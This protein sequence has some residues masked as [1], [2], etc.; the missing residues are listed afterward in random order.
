MSYKT[1]LP[2]IALVLSPACLWAANVDEGDGELTISRLDCGDILIKDFNAFFSDA[3][4]LPSGPWQ[5]TSSC[6][7]IRH[8]DDLMLWDTGFSAALRDQPIEDDTWRATLDVLLAEQLADGGL[9][10][11]EIDVVGI[12][13]MHLDHVGQVGD[14]ASATLVV[15]S[16]DF[17]RTEGREGDPYAAFRDEDAKVRR[18]GGGDLDI[19]GDGSVIALSLP[20]HTPGHL[21]LQV[22]LASGPVLLV[23]DLYHSREAREVGSMPSW[24]TSR[25]DTLASMDRFDAMAKNLDADVVIQH[26][27]DDIEKIPAFP[28]ERK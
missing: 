11:E 4:E 13:H 28:L 1:I 3:Y 9:A 24:N 16:E 10:A 2:A 21:G 15:G 17:T 18:V 14:F 25:A 26:D 22:N 27:P 12:S 8:G 6:Y 19:F 7:L 23:G 20:G 5:G